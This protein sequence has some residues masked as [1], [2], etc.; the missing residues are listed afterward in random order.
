M[1]LVLIVVRVRP[2]VRFAWF[3]LAARKKGTG[4]F[5]YRLTQRWDTRNQRGGA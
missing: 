2:V 1:A 5:S 3:E 4:L